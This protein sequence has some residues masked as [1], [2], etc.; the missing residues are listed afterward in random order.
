MAGE[1]FCIEFDS[2]SR[3]AVIAKHNGQ[4]VWQPTS[5]G[6]EFNKIAN[7]PV[8]ASSR[9]ARLR[10]LKVL[11]KRFRSTLLGWQPGNAQREELRLLPSP[12]YRYRI[13]QA[14]DLLDGALFAF[15]SGT[16]PESL[17][18]LEAVRGAN[19]YSWEYAFA[20]CSSGA[21]EGRLDEKLV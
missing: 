9:P 4:V 2:L 3:G 5:A 21:L 15:A 11:A 18:V 14:G 7:S 20:R 12:I 17:L 13:R 19:A 10:Q 6:L 8:P 16:D 1:K